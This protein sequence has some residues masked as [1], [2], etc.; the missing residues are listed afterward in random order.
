MS[1][2]YIPRGLVADAIEVLT[3]AGK[4]LRGAEL[5]AAIGCEAKQLQSILEWAIVRGLVRT[6]RDEEDRRRLV[7]SLGDGTPPAQQGADEPGGLPG[8]RGGA[9]VVAVLY[10][11]GTIDRVEP[12]EP[13][14]LTAVERQAL[15]RLL[16]GGKA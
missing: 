14:E 8:A 15:R 7:W 12:G 1:R 5:G 13:G 9:R 3:R 11:D 4:P 2:E 16:A 6:E 10:S